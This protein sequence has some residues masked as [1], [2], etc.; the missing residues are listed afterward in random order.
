VDEGYAVIK[1]LCDWVVGGFSTG[2]GLAL[3]LAARVN[4]VK[5]VFTICSPMRIRFLSS[6]FAPAV[7]VW[8]RLLKK[9]RVEENPGKILS[10]WN[11]KTAI[12]NIKKIRFPEF[13]K[14][15]GS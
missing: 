7:D 10:M 9:I 11:L 15:N 14:W 8:N 6:R 5:G 3:D 4:D 2:A 12:S 1:S 13:G